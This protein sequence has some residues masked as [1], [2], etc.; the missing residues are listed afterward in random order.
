[1]KTVKLSLSSRKNLNNSYFLGRFIPEK[2]TKSL[3]KTW[4]EDYPELI[5]S[6][7]IEIWDHRARLSRFF[8]FEVIFPEPKMTAFSVMYLHLGVI[9]KKYNVNQKNF[10]FNSQKI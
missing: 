10:I 8:W 2:I 9:I 7:C 4:V 5:S 3:R 1:M 6:V